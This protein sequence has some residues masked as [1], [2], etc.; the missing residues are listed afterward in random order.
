MAV[1]AMGKD[2]VGTGRFFLELYRKAQ[3][4]YDKELYDYFLDHAVKVTNSKIGFFHIVGNDQ[5]TI[6]LTT[7]NKEVL[8]NCTAIYTAHYPIDQ[9]G[10]WVDCVHLK[11]PVIYND[12]PS[13]PNQKGLPKGHISLTRMLST[14]I[15]EDGKVSAI[16]GVG[17]KTEPYTEDDVVQLDIIS[18][19]LNKIMKQRHAEAELLESKEKYQTLFTNMLNGFAYCMILF[20]ENG[21][22]YDYI[23]LEGNHALE[24]ILG[25]KMVDF[26]GKKATELMPE[27]RKADQEVF[28]RYAK[29]ALNGTEDKFEFLFKPLGIWLSASVY[30]PKKGYFAAVLE[31]ITERKKAEA[32]LKESEERLRHSQEIAHVG[33]WIYDT[34]QGKIKWSD[35]IYRI[36]GLNPEEYDGTFDDLLK[37]VPEEEREKVKDS[38]LKAF[39]S[40][41]GIDIEHRVIRKKTGETRFVHMKCYHVRDETGKTVR[42]VGMAQDITEQKRTQQALTESE[43][44]LQLKLDSLLSPDIEIDD[45]ELAN[46]IDVKSLQVIMDYLSRVT[47]IAFALID[48]KGKILVSA[49][50]QEIC[51]KLHRLNQETLKNCIE[52]DMELTKGIKRGEIRLYKCKNN[53]WDV[54]TP[55]FIGNKH[56]SNV[57]FGQ[58]FF[59]DE[60]PDRK[61]FEAQAEK[62][63][64]NKEEYLAAFDRVPRFNR[65]NMEALMLFYVRLTETISNVSH[66]NL[67]LAKALNTQKQLQ[68]QLE[69]KASEVEEYASEMEE[70]AEDRARQL[71]DAERLSAI[72]ATAGMVGH[73]I[74][75]PLQAITNHLYLTRRKADLLPNGEIKQSIEK[76]IQNSEENLRYIN[77]IVADLQDFAAPLNP[78]RER[79]KIEEAIRDA[80]AMVAAPENIVITVDTPETLP[81]LYADY[82]MLKRILVNLMQN[83]VQ[84][85]PSGGKLIVSATKTGQHIE[86]IIEDTGEGIPPEVQVKIFTPLIT[87]K[88]KG[89]GFGLAVVK[90]MTEGMGGTVTFET[91]SGKGTKFTLKFPV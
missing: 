25:I 78:K 68:A 39:A 42:I 62:Y 54:A 15:L 10:N 84:A 49:G 44:R 51:V 58:F 22:P 69:K 30:C 37:S 4:L 70:L 88:P 50:W 46:I 67:K 85:M 55:L 24:K 31:N 19:E 5:K 17:N 2:T 33:S 1:K 3:S 32:A 6:N 34:S 27:L 56:V 77:K 75:N 47:N 9:A 87:T 71:K 13:S 41:S 52:S 65:K 26:I 23:V 80:L 35:E 53:L 66:A 7:W 57:F 64:F 45:Q 8:Q 91:E 61:L 36:W 89:Q 79:L 14:P 12:F 74:R 59:D 72:G 11:K 60:V 82:T 86:F 20:D 40:G 90:R 76:N 28:E 43:E 81:P 63:G 18:S 38:V 48:L 83:A 21:K 16:F 73:D 29:V